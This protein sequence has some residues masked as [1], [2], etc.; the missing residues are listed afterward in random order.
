MHPR[1]IAF[2]PGTLGGGA[3]LSIRWLGT[4][5]FELAAEG[6]TVLFDPYLTRASLLQCVASRLEPNL[7]LLAQHLPRA[8]AIVVGHTHFDHALDVPAVARRTGARVFGSRSAACLCRAAGVAEAQIDVV[9]GGPGSP[10]VVREVGPF[11]LVFHPSAHSPL[12][13]G[14]VP[15]EG[16]I[17]D[18]D[19]VP[20]R[21]TGYRCGAVFGVEVRVLG[22]TLFHVGSAEV[23]P[24]MPRL[25]VD[26]AL[27]CVA[28]WTTTE[29]FPERL[30][31]K[32]SPRAIV[33]SHWDNF[34]LPLAK[35]AHPL[36]AMQMPRLVDRL[37]QASRDV[38]V[39]TLPF[40]R[41]VQL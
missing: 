31:R 30:A 3:P 5:G 7:G 40:M 21:A 16:E 13:L 32:L 28:G 12:L 22:R 10:P 37:V 19:A 20:E 27:M 11:T 39:G 29:A 41:P 6:H 35:G 24:Q 15:F 26:V 23:L 14:R 33:L 2:E 4:A 25:E 1:E 8:D 9:E 18:C 38:R 34:L 17:A 36:P